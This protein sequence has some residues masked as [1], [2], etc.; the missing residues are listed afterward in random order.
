MV[1]CKVNDPN[2]FRFF[3]ASFGAQPQE[4]KAETMRCGTEYVD[5]VRMHGFDYFGVNRASVPSTFSKPQ[6][7]TARR[8]G[9]RDL[10]FEVSV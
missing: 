6:F 9:L 4:A 5:D 8:T 1:Q 3:Y 7:A 2:R 10:P